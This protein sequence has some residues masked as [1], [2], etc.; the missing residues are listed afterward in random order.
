MLNPFPQYVTNCPLIISFACNN[1]GS[2]YFQ[3]T[4]VNVM[5]SQGLTANVISEAFIQNAN[6]TTLLP[7]STS[8]LSAV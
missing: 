2:G 6:V 3:D 5:N 1:K 4:T 8:G 7:T